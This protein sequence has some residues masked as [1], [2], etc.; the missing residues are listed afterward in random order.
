MSKTA[1]DFA[2]ESILPWDGCPWQ[3]KRDGISWKFNNSGPNVTTSNIS[4]L[5]FKGG[6]KPPKSVNSTLNPFGGEYGFDKV[7]DSNNKVSSYKLQVVPDW[8]QLTWIG[9]A[10]S[11]GQLQPNACSSMYRDSPIPPKQ[12]AGYTSDLESYHNQNMQTAFAQGCN[13]CSVN[14]NMMLCTLDDQMLPS[15]C[16]GYNSFS[17]KPKVVNLRVDTSGSEYYTPDASLYPRGVGLCEYP[18]NIINTDAELS[19]LLRLKNEN[20][21]HP[22]L[23]DNLAANYCYR[24]TPG[25][26]GKDYDGK[27]IT[28]CPKFKVDEK[29]ADSSSRPCTEWIRSKS[30]TGNTAGRKMLDDLSIQWCNDINHTFTPLCDCLK[31]DVRSASINIPVR[32]FYNTLTS[33]SVNPEVAKLTTAMPAH[34]WFKPCTEKEYALPLLT[35]EGSCPINANVCNQIN[36][37]MDQA[38]IEGVNQVLNCTATL[39]QADVTTQIDY[40]G[41]GSGNGNPTI[42]NAD[43]LKTELKKP[44]IWIPLLVITLFSLGLLYM[45]LFTKKPTQMNP[46]SFPGFPGFSNYQSQPQM[47]YRA[48]MQYQAPVSNPMPYRAP[49]QYQAPVSNP[50][51]YQ[52]PVS[53]PMQYQAPVSNPM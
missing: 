27:D 17:T 49:I 16:P 29:S 5:P 48:P 8:S 34:C 50:M 36:T 11:C 26:C 47:T 2:R 22:D 51:Q 1:A 6:W 30:N 32:N 18:V 46:L 25:T 39:A 53:N 37:S 3:G 38:T 4:N 14:H 44:V 52:A 42:S 12:W 41:S 24:D 15:S 7:Y 43:R 40:D 19:A 28:I 45:K 9:T 31:K 20:A 10:P 23:A 13:G 35:T 33:M 21:I